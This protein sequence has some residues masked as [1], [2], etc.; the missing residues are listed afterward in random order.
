MAVSIAILDDHQIVI[1][2]LKLLLS[3]HNQFKIVA[4]YNRGYDLLEGL[5]NI[6][7]EPTALLAEATTGTPLAQDSSADKQKVSSGP[8]AMATSAQDR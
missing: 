3:D 7:V 6:N 8:G 4:E 1:D 2:G 5:K